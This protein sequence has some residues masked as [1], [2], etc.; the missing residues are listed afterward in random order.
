M[1]SSLPPLLGPVSTGSSFMIASIRNNV[2]YILNGF[3]PSGQSSISYYWESNLA[4]IDTSTKMGVFIAQGTLGSM[5][6][7][8]TINSGGIGFASDGVTIGNSALPGNVKMSQPLYA[9]WFPPDIFL[10]AVTYTMYNASNGA[11]AQIHTAPSLTSSTVPANDIVILPVWWYF[12][13]TSS[14]SYQYINEPLNS[15]ANWV[16]LA[17]TGTT[18]C[19]GLS[20]ASGGWTNLSDCM[21]GNKYTYCTSGNICGNSNCKGP[22]SVIYDDCNFSSGNYVCVFDPKKYFTDTK[23]WESP[24]FIGAVIGIIVIITILLLVTIAVSRHGQKTNK[25]PPGGYESYQIYD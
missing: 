23:W 9:N 13:C 15:V 10:S 21:V 3:T 16:C 14:G 22:C 8:D 17:A 19:S 7:K 4:T 25:S 24:Y 6:L 11:T 18:G 20:I 5:I 2:P 12:N 1:S